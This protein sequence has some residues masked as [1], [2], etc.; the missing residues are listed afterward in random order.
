L[1]YTNLQSRTSMERQNSLLRMAAGPKFLFV[2]NLHWLASLLDMRTLR[3]FQAFITQSVHSVHQ[4][5][6]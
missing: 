3:Q 1:P 4:S 2:C 5:I 6:Y